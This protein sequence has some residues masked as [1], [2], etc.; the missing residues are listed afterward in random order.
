MSSLDTLPRPTAVLFGLSG[1]LVDFG[2]RTLTDAL[3][4]MHQNRTIAPNIHPG[5]LD[6]SPGIWLEPSLS[7]EKQ[8][9]LEQLLLKTAGKSAVP[10][11]GALELLESLHAQQIPCI[12]LED[13]PA[14]VSACLAAPLPGWLK[15]NKSDKQR[16]WPAPD[17]CWTALM[18]L[19]V[20]S[21]EGSILVSSEPRLLQAGLKAGLWTV[22]LATCGRLCGKGPADWQAL[23]DIQREQLR[24]QATLELYRLGTHSVIDHLGE[25]GL[26]LEDLAARRKRGQ[27]P[28]GT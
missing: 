5:D 1:C 24:T 27:K 17:A 15:G 19:K 6:H 10:T 12:W 4:L 11:Q 3:Q 21:L 2:A 26:C 13:L 18:E 28:S 16:P 25:L 9:E 8:A 20:D 22:G 7:T 23:D 14:S